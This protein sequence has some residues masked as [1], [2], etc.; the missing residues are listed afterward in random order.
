M[1]EDR[2][3]E[4]HR[5]L[6]GALDDSLVRPRDLLVTSD[7]RL[8]GFPVPVRT[9]LVRA[10]GATGYIYSK[11][12]ERR[13]A[14]S[15]EQFMG[16]LKSRFDLCKKKS[17]KDIS[18]AD[19]EKSLCA[20][21]EDLFSIYKLEETGG[22]PQ[23]VYVEGD[24]FVFE[25]RSKESP[26]GRR[27]MTFEDAD[28]QRMSFGTRVRF[29]NPNSYLAMQ[30]DELFDSYTMSWLETD[31]E[32]RARK[33]AIVGGRNSNGPYAVISPETCHSSRRGWRGSVRVKKVQ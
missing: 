20:N 3:A 5:M 9:G 8:V 21:P 2:D 4:H 17:F 28:A 29:Q 23:L 33:E 27:S 26:I 22:E 24:E 15:P 1:P 12:K 10:L 11:D 31:D 25:D 14:L 7:P 13:Q 16:K 19:V 30:K 6:E 18:W 32:T